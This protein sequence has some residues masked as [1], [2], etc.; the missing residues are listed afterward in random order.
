MTY[1]TISHYNL[2]YINALQLLK[3]P[4]LRF[5]QLLKV[6]TAVTN[7]LNDTLVKLNHASFDALLCREYKRHKE[8]EMGITR[9]N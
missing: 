7:S 8:Q 9:Q 3:V 2:F 4:N 6:K 1:L 5:T